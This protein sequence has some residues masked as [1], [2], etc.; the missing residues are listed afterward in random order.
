M[1]QYV[2]N[3][4]SFKYW[5]REFHYGPFDEKQAEL[6]SIKEK[7]REDANTKCFANIPKDK[8][9]I[10]G[11]IDG[12]FRKVDQ[13]F[14]E[15]LLAKEKEVKEKKRKA[16]ELRKKSK[17]QMFINPITGDIMDPR[18]PTFYK[19]SDEVIYASNRKLKFTVL[20]DEIKIARKIYKMKCKII[21]YKKLYKEKEKNIPEFSPLHPFRQEEYLL[22]MLYLKLE[23]QNMEKQIGYYLDPLTGYHINIDIPD[24]KEIEQKHPNFVRICVNKIQEFSKRYIDPILDGFKEFIDRNQEVLTQIASIM[25][26]IAGAMLRIAVIV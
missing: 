10:C 13:L 5:A 8:P 2:D 20:N 25:G 4:K 23:I 22:D 19:Q 6:Q 3:D 7:L 21:E 11:D 1:H 9:I 14:K 26:T 12:S 18:T 24:P 15:Q 16:K 17:A